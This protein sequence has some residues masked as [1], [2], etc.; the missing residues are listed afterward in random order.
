MKSSPTGEEIVTES[1]QITT[2]TNVA[3]RT[4]PVLRPTKSR[5]NSSSSSLTS[6]QDLPTSLHESFNACRNRITNQLERS[7]EQRNEQREEATMTE[8]FLERVDNESPNIYSSS[9]QQQQQQQQHQSTNLVDNDLM[10]S[11]L[12][13]AYASPYLE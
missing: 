4:S 6:Y 10:S 13:R 8:S 5:S 11:T 7:F 1:K 2:T 9:P 12:R 3:D